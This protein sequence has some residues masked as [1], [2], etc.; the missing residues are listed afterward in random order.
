MALILTVLENECRCA[1][2]DEITTDGEMN[3]FELRA[4][5]DHENAE[6]KQKPAG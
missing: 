2:S 4:W 6:E 3:G 5:R 1:S